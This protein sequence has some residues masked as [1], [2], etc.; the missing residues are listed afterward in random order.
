MSYVAPVTRQKTSQ[1][2]GLP[3]RTGPV[4]HGRDRPKGSR[5][6]LLVLLAAGL[7]LTAWAIIEAG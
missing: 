4:Y 2:S 1:A 7:R 6:F 3:D 5:E